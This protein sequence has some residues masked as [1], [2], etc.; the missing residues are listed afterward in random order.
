M[1][2][3]L[4]RIIGRAKCLFGRHTQCLWWTVDG[5]DLMVNRD[6]VLDGFESTVVAEFD[7]AV[8]CC[9]CEKEITA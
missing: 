3:W 9:Y 5:F 7:A 1:P 8:C 2:D 4:E 6:E